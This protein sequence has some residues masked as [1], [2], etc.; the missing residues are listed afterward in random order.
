MATTVAGL[1]SNFDWKSFIDQIMQVERVPADRLETEKNVNSQKVA[2]LSNLGTRM[3]ALQTAAKALEANGVFGQ[4]TTKSLTS[5]STWSTSAASGTATGTYKIAVSQVATAASRAS[6]TN[7]ASPLSPTDDVAGLTLA[8]LSVASGINAGTFTVNGHKVTVALTDSLKDVFDAISL[9]TSG[10][11]TASYDSAADKITLTSATDDVMIGAANDTSNFLR[12]LKL[13][14][15]GTDTITSSARLGTVKTS[16][17]LASSNLATAITAVNGTGDG[18]FSINGVSIAY[19][20]N[21][22]TVSAVLKRINQSTAGVNANY[23]T[24][25]DRFSLANS[26]TGDLG[27]SVSED[28]GGF[29]NALGLMGG[30]A[31]VRG[32]DA[33]FTIGGGPVLTSAS[34]T[35]SSSA[36]GVTGLSI[37]VTGTETQ[38]IE[39]AANT[40]SMQTKI[41]GFL[42]KFNEVQDYLTSVTKVSTD[43]KGKVTAAV[44]ASN[45]EIQEWGRSLRTLAFNSLAGMSGTVTRLEQLGIDFKKG[46]SNLEI[47]DTAK[48]TEALTNRSPDVSQFFDTRTTGFAARLDQFIGKISGQNDDQQKRLNK[49]NTNIDAQIEAIERHLTQQ[50]SLM[51]SAFIQMETAQSKLKSQQSTIDRVF[52]ISSS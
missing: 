8:T 28:T 5:G 25:N 42:D 15:N 39:V 44:L 37:S 36:H 19:N 49:N 48:L 30:A 35:L 24:V 50:R 23:D 2:L 41:Q 51:E 11:V 10:D 46:S 31:F 9:A 33:K 22:D 7:G 21:T 34:N 47:S 20:V 12:A 6:T 38:T 26:S 1:A 13:G 27:I 52:S 32:D 4:R 14:N 43:S 40:D 45:R 17:P 29:L 18:S 3:T 16:S